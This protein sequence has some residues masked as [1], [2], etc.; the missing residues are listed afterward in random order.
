MF[1]ERP[2]P[3]VLARAQ[4]STVLPYTS[5]WAIPTAPKALQ[6]LFTFC[7]LQLRL[8]GWPHPCD[9]LLP[10]PPGFV[11]ACFLSFKEAY[12]RTYQ[13]IGPI[14]SAL[15]FPRFASFSNSSMAFLWGKGKMSEKQPQMDF[16][17]SLLHD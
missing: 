3:T 5:L 12:L 8:T 9:I 4:L 7:S 15:V 13:P 10:Q 2:L 17:K 6:P 14:V 1:S 16:W 11:V